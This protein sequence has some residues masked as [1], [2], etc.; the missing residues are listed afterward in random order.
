M[1][2]R[3]NNPYMQMVEDHDK[4]INLDEDIYKNKWMWNKYF[5]NKN[6]IVLEI[7][8]WMWNYFSD[9][10]SKNLNKNYI[11]MEI[12]FKR[13]YNTVEKS[14]TKWATDN[15]VAIQDYWQKIDRI[16]DTCEISKVVVHFP[17]P[18]G[19]KDRQKKHRLFSQEF[20]DNLYNVLIDWWKI[21]FKTDH[22]EYFETTLEYFNS[23]KWKSDVLSFDYEKEL[24]HFN[25]DTMTE[26]EH[27][28]R[29]D[30]CKINYVEFIK[31]KI[32]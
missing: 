22:R 14:K 32:V 23:N 26:F 1:T 18:W 17:D 30:K 8:T 20:V 21:I 4:I 7:W 27:I 11:W 12:K 29:K 9:E 5:W 10:S 19:K 6:E 16:F 25:T 31:E 13:L 2:H 15:Y 3:K 24:E 28:F